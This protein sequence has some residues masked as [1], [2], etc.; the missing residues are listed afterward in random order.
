MMPEYHIT[1]Q[2]VGAVQPCPRGH[3]VGEQWDLADGCPAGLCHWAWNSIYPFYCVLR[4]GGRLPW[5]GTDEWVEVSCPDPEAT[6]RI[7]LTINPLE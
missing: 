6:Q 5:Q 3:K 7:R 4:Y 2:I 1:A